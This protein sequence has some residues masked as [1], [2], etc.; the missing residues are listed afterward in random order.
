MKI[1]NAEGRVFGCLSAE[2]KAELKAASR[3]AGAIIENMDMQGWRECSN[4][5]WFISTA[6]RVTIPDAPPK[7]PKCG[8]KL[9]RHMNP[10]TGAI[11]LGN[12]LRCVKCQHAV[13]DEPAKTTRCGCGTATTQCVLPVGHQGGCSIQPRDAKPEPVPVKGTL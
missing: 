13:K 9:Y 2:N 6:Y 12:P 5:A 3:V 7:C 8:G 4:A 1:L 10:V 11:D